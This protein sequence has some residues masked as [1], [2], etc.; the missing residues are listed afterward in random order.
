MPPPTLLTPRPRPRCWRCSAGAG[1][2]RGAQ[3]RTA[4]R[5]ADWRAA[6]EQ[7]ARRRVVTRQSCLSPPRARPKQTT[8]ARFISAADADTALSGLRS[9][10]YPAIVEF[11][12]SQSGLVDVSQVRA[13][14]GCTRYH[15]DK[16]AGRG[17]IALETEEVWRDPLAGQVFVPT[18]PPP[19]TP[20]QA[21][22]WDA[23]KSPI[24]QSPISNSFF[25]TA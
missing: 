22:V 11:L 6:A 10:V 12:R 23:I 14:T 13:E 18:E 15:L 4:L 7:L 19:L 9:E 1:P 8:T 21:A 20:D 24:L 17:L 25:S 16:L 5:T 2:L 3:V